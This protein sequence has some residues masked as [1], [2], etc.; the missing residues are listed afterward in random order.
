MFCVLQKVCVWGNPLPTELT[1]K[2]MREEQQ[3][4]TAPFTI[5][6]Y[7]MPVYIFNTVIRVQQAKVVY[8]NK[9]ESYNWIITD[10]VIITLLQLD[11]NYINY[12][13]IISCDLWNYQSLDFNYWRHV[14]NLSMSA[15][16]RHSIKYLCQSAPPIF[17]AMFNAKEALFIGK[18]FSLSLVYNWWNSFN[19]AME[20]KLPLILIKN[21]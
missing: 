6:V 8:G 13:L 3:N 20:K 2:K 18:T 11:Y 4:S 9:T 15:A 12:V 14:K 16:F 19:F 1:R 7:I 21:C 17:S 10:T 5:T